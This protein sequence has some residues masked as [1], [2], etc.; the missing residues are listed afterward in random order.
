MPLLSKEERI[1]KYGTPTVDT[2]TPTETPDSSQEQFSNLFDLP[3]NTEERVQAQLSNTR[4]ELRNGFSVTDLEQNYGYR[5]RAERFLSDVGTDD[6]IFETLRDSKYNTGM[7]LLQAFNS[8]KWTEQTKEDYRVLSTL[9][10]EANTEGASEYWD[11]TKNIG[12]DVVTDPVNLLG[13]FFSGFLAKSV[14]RRVGTKGAAA[15]AGREAGEEVFELATREVAERTAARRATGEVVEESAEATNKQVQEAIQFIMNK[16]AAVENVAV[17]L[18][19]GAIDGGIYDIAQ[20]TAEK[21]IGI[22]DNINL[23]RTLGIAGVGA[24]FG[25]ALGMAGNSWIKASNKKITNVIGE[26]VVDEALDVV[27]T[28]VKNIN[29]WKKWIDDIASK[30]LGRATAK[31]IEY[32]ESS[33]AVA[34]LINSISSDATTRV[35]EGTKK[36]SKSVTQSYVS[37]R[38][39]L[40]GGYEGEIRKA[41]NSIVS[42][43]D[44]EA[45]FFARLFGHTLPEEIEINVANLVSMKKA[46]F[47]KLIKL[48]GK[49]TSG[50]L[51]A[52]NIGNKN[53]TGSFDK[54]VANYGL[55]VTTTYSPSVLEASVRI[56]NTIEKVAEEASNIQSVYG[57]KTF[58]I[59]PDDS[60]Q[61]VIDGYFP[62]IWED[63]AIVAQKKDVLVGLLI[64]HGSARLKDKT[65]GASEL[66]LIIKRSGYEDKPII[67]ILKDDPNA[68][69][70]ITKTGAGGK[71]TEEDYLLRDLADSES[72]SVDADLYSSFM[73]NVNEN[74]EQSFL[75]TAL[76]NTESGADWVRGVRLNIRKETGA[77]LSK[78]GITVDDLKKW[79]PK[80]QVSNRMEDYSPIYIE[81]ITAA[82][83]KLK[84]NAIVDTMIDARSSIISTSSNTKRT[85]VQFTKE[86]VFK[87]IPDHELRA[88]GLVKTRGIQQQLN[89]YVFGMGEAIA[90]TKYFGATEEAFGRNYLKQARSELKKAGLSDTQIEDEVAKPLTDL[91]LSITNQSKGSRPTS[92]LGQYLFDWGLLTQAMA[93]L[94]LAV[95]SSIT[96][97]LLLMTRA[98]LADLPDAYKIARSLMDAQFK[99]TIDSF[100]VLGRKV[101]GKETTGYK[102]LE[103]I[104]TSDP[105]KYQDFFEGMTALNTAAVRVVGFESD[106]LTTGFAKTATDVYFKTTLLNT[107][108][109]TVRAAAYAMAK[110]RIHRLTKELA[111]GY[112]SFGRKLGR[113]AMLERR[114]GLFEVGIDAKKSLAHYRESTVDNVLDWNKWRSGSF[115]DND[116]S[117]GASLFSHE[118]ILNANAAEA[119]KPLWMGSMAGRLFTQFASYPLAFNN[120]VLRKTAN[121]IGANYKVNGPKAF[122]AAML[123]SSVAILGN[124]ARRGRMPNADFRDGLDDEELSSLYLK[125]FQRAGGLGPFDYAIRAGEA[126][127]YNVNT[128]G[129]AV[130]T[131]GGPLIQDIVALLKGYKTGT[132][133]LVDNLPFSGL[134]TSEERRNLR[135]WTRAKVTPYKKEYSY[136]NTNYKGGLISNVPNVNVEPDERKIRGLPYSYSQAAGG[137]MKE[138]EDRLGFQEGGAVSETDDDFIPIYKYLTKDEKYYES[139]DKNKLEMYDKEEVPEPSVDKAMFIGLDDNSYQSLFNESREGSEVGV[140]V[141]DSPLKTMKPTRFKGFIKFTNAVE[142]NSPTT[143]PED[144][145]T[146][147]RNIDVSKSFMTEKNAR[148]MIKEIEALLNIRDETLRKDPNKTK[149]KEERMRESKSFIIRDRL[150]RMGYDAIKF[151][152]GYSLLK[153]NGFFPTEEVKRGFKEGGLVDRMRKRKGYAEG[154]ETETQLY[155]NITNYV[156]RAT[157][158]QEDEL[159]GTQKTYGEVVGNT[160][161]INED[162]LIERGSTGNFVQ[163]M[164]V[165]E[166]LH[167]LSKSAPEWYDRLYQA[168]EN[169][170]A[171]QKWKQDAFII[172]KERGED[173]GRTIDDWWKESRFDQ[174]VGGFILAGENANVHTMRTWSQDS[175]N[176]GTTFRKELE[177]FEG[178]LGY[179]R[180]YAKGGLVNT[181]RNRKAYQDGGEAVTLSNSVLNTIAERRGWTPDQIANVKAFAD[182]VSWIESNRDALAI[183]EGGPGRGKY[184]YELNEGGS[185]RNLDSQR[186]YKIFQPR[187]NQIITE[188]EQRFL[189]D[190]DPDMS[191]YSEELQDAVFYADYSTGDVP[192]ADIANGKI[193]FQDAWLQYHWKGAELGSDGYNKK[194]AYAQKREDEENN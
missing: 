184:Q 10:E 143:S 97:P 129:T 85:G 5:E 6:N 168:A 24:A 104:L 167:R 96:E 172:A 81:D 77:D 98:D 18:T 158:E 34:K 59:N 138:P 20:Q 68:T 103:E 113:D 87:N 73:K 183:Q 43:G 137:I 1:Q 152:N 28:G 35:F 39:Q 131:V 180:G 44:K 22:R 64:K 124:A 118:I 108:T 71:V 126:R 120:I 173:Q 156:T 66:D 45:G 51:Q 31:F 62:R 190:P 46:D 159:F 60:Y 38:D 188:E 65:A 94:P 48:A 165:G 95:I 88:A 116:I 181:L 192:L 19:A 185:G 170:P 57:G 133:I 125:G 9:F 146:E 147:L 121:S 186:N 8:R 163:D 33:P 166:A 3:A 40:I 15:L 132:D 26:E 17:G 14:L 76:L 86:R 148:S 122:G 47:D 135:E 91:Y 53:L 145:M 32:S 75:M 140:S 101:A 177:D 55:D 155:K 179:P 150:L 84:A 139:Y 36:L 164:Y 162:F 100:N 194:K 11:A 80:R 56:R 187:T 134:A 79:T 127:K 25:G 78:I 70:K 61:G 67:Q 41:F 151:N 191:Q 92:K 27:E 89:S 58:I 112:D 175:P 49:D 16:R 90:N 110:T 30:S 12:F 178:A 23:A 74:D 130:G 189:D 169:D 37:F 154:G 149:A 123:I 4:Q 63:I 29:S 109:H 160:A 105:H 117:S 136:R 115:Y 161:Y 52:L 7:A 153:N 141:Y 111:T 144:I 21:N 42:S 69:V 142:I 83:E 106:D 72:L 2:V 50:K 193:S 99:K 102:T 174:V 82:A 182:Y 119:S 13:G 157:P 54:L 107:W 93:H 114:Q 128:F 176:F 171:V